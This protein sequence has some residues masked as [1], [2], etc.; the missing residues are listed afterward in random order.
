MFPYPSGAGLHVGHPE[1]YTATDIV[2]RY[3]RMRRVQ[4]AASRWAGTPSACPPSSTPSRPAPI[5]RVTTQREHRHLPAPDPVASASATTGTREVDTT[6]PDYFKWTQWIF[7][8]LFER[9]LAYQSRGP[10]ELVPG[11][12]HRAGQRRGHRRQERARRPSR[13][14]ACPC[15]SGCCASPP[16][17]TGC[18]TT[19]TWSTGRTA[20][21][22]C[23]GTGSAAAK[24]PRCGSR[25]RTATASWRSS[26]P[27]PTRCSAPPT[28]SLAPE[29]PLRRTP[30]HPRPEGRGRGLRPPG[31]QPLGPGPEGRQGEDRRL[32]RR[33]RA[34]PR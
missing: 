7:L 31:R 20:S 6:D 8:Q 10:G 3:K 29:H 1:G 2:A 28:W 15:A 13:R 4:R 30:H 23:S 34:Q 32:H 25:W 18:W 16:T 12:G 11:P 27:A 33:L 26:P 22:R 9:G 5:R 19:W 21:R 14:A 24:A 17:P